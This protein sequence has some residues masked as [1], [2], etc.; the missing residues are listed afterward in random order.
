M[1]ILSA[2]CPAISDLF[3]EIESSWS[4]LQRLRKFKKWVSPLWKKVRKIWSKCNDTP[5]GYME[6]EHYSVSLFKTDSWDYLSISLLYYTILSIR[7]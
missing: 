6:A 7:W 1:L 4:A 5:S 3:V 2:S